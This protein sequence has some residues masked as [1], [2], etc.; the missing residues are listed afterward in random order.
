[1]IVDPRDAVKR[2]YWF[3]LWM[4]ND[5]NRVFFVFTIKLG[6]KGETPCA[7]E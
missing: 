6:D 2:Q 3:I 4:I 1:M 5:R 7:V